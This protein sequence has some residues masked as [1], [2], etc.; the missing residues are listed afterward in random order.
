M[1]FRQVQPANICV[2]LLHP[3]KFTV[4]R[5]MTTPELS[6]ESYSQTPV[7]SREVKGLPFLATCRLFSN[8][9]AGQTT[10]RIEWWKRI[11][12][13]VPRDHVNGE[14]RTQAVN[15]VLDR[16]LT[17][18]AS[19]RNCNVLYALLWCSCGTD[20]N[21]INTR[22]CDFCWDLKQWLKQQR[23]EVTH[24]RWFIFTVI[25]QQDVFRFQI[26]EKKK[27]KIRLKYIM[28][29]PS[30]GERK[31][32]E[33]WPVDYPLSVQV[34]QAATDLSSVEHG[35]LLIKASFPHVVDVKL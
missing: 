16:A 31:Q 3:N 33:N 7:T 8:V 15:S 10:R 23:S 17:L 19:R 1:H 11:F 30:C 21:L 6:R 25:I 26:P 34:L 18:T 14:G 4:T 27:N 32:C 35:S 28:D 22:P 20:R 5:L 24:N 9:P 12:R 29:F 13:D 2:W